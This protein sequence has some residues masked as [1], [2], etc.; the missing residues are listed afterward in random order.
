MIVSNKVT[1]IKFD[2]DEMKVLEQAGAILNK[3][4]IKV[5]DDEAEWGD[6]NIHQLKEL[7]DLFLE[8]SKSGVAEMY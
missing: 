6:Y 5:T 4:H 3:I 2:E 8:A 1:T 7:S